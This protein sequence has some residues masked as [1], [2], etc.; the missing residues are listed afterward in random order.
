[1]TLELSCKSEYALLALVELT[2]H[3]ATGEPLQIQHL[4][5]RQNIPY[6]YLEQLLATLKRFK[7]VRSQRGAHGGYLL[8][9]EP[10]TIT[11]LEIVTAIEGNYDQEAETS[12]G[13]ELTAGTVV[14]NVWHEVRQAADL[15]LQSYTLQ[16]VADQWE[17]KRQCQQS[18]MYYI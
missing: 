13:A 7:L 12:S 6:R 18:I 3:Y 15:V 10:W 8:A 1:M 9:R 11:L 17:A 5:T 14:H 4:A 16:D 2:T